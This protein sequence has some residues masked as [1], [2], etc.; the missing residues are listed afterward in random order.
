[1]R[2]RGGSVPRAAGRAAARRG[3]DGR[4]ALPRRGRHG[5]GLVGV[6][7]LARGRRPGV[8]AFLVVL[9]GAAAAANGADHPAAEDD[10]RSPERRA[11]YAI[12]SV[13]WIMNSSGMVKA[14]ARHATT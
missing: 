8:G 3:R 9:G 5:R 12:S 2:L 14:S 1:L 4:R 6:L 11:V 10:G 7:R 13:I